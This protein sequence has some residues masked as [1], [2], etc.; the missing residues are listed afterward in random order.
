MKQ[1][2]HL[3]D[4]VQDVEPSYHKILPP[5]KQ[6]LYSLHQKPTIE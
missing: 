3:P 1:W 5:I 2:F 6:T 4:L